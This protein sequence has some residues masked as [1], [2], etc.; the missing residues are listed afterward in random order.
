MDGVGDYTRRLAAELAARGHSAYLLS[1]ADAH[2]RQVSA[3]EF[4][5]AG[6]LV[7]YLR[8]PS[9]ETWSERVHQGKS[10]CRQVAPDW[11]SLQMVPYGF[12]PRGLSFGLGRRVAEMVGPCK[13]QV[14]FHEIWIGE[15]EGSSLKNQFIGRLQKHIVHDLLKKLHPRVVHTH[16]PLYRHL[17]GK[18]GYDATILPLFGNISLSNELKENECNFGLKLDYSER[19]SYWIFVM[20]GTIHPEWDAREFIGKATVAAQ[21]VGK[22]CLLISIG[23][24]GPAGE[25]LMED[26]RKQE[27]KVWQIFILGQKSEEEISR[28]LLAADFGVTAVPPEYLF[29]SGTA[30]AMIERGLPIIATRSS[31]RYPNCPVDVVALGMSN[32]AKDFNLESLRKSKIESLLPGVATRFMEDLQRADSV[33]AL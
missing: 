24:P 18:L 11:V 21:R 10:F 9:S 4:S 31:Y 20:F 17:L 30:A 33:A 2:V 3:G 7:P 5:D 16:T 6:A 8:L 25:R 27:G 23:R 26:L 28:C 14:M 19:G 1:I 32:V 22:K 15:A 12:N 13:S 29:K